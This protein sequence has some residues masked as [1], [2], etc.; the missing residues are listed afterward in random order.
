[1]AATGAV[2]ILVAG[3]SSTG[4]DRV[5]RPTQPTRPPATTQVTTGVTKP[6]ATTSLARRQIGRITIDNADGLVAALGF[7]WVKTDDGRLVKVD[8][9]TNRIVG[10]RKLD[11]ATD[12]SRYCQGI[13]T[14]G[15]SVWACATTDTAT[16]VVQ[17]DPTSLAPVQRVRVNKV[18]DQLR[19]PFAGDKLWVL[20]AD[21]SSLIGVDPATAAVT[22]RKLPVRCLQLFGSDRTLLATCR[23]DNLVLRI[24][25]ASGTVSARRSIASPGFAVT[26][27]TDTWVDTSEGV[28][29]LDPALRTTAVYPELVVGLDGDL[30]VDDTGAIWARQ[31]SGFLLRIDPNRNAVVER[32]AAP[33]SLSGGSLLITGD[34]IWTTASDDAALLRLRR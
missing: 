27:G 13:G 28:Q 24:D 18:F 29:R 17:V 25:P 6:L 20:G 15:K 22:S 31:Q 34:S 10:Q 8:P 9:R 14:D 7:I 16:D 30:A 26:S 1:M 4:R 32:V 2:V 11:T 3:C 33:A 21:G 19:L 12:S 5:A 23:I